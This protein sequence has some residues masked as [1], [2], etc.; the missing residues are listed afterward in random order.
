MTVTQ[1]ASEDA[2]F[3]EKEAPPLSEEFPI[4]SKVFFLGEHAYGVAAQVSETTKDTLSIILAVRGELS[5]VR[6]NTHQCLSLV[7]PFGEDRQREIQGDR[8]QSYL[9]AVLPGV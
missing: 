3:I 4:G 2:R 9:S 8:Q 1:V 6:T 5:S 7:L